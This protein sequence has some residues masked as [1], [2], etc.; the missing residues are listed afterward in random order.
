MPHD[1]HD[2]FH[3]EGMSSSGHPYRPDNE[4][5][6]TYWQQ[7]EIAVRELLVE[8]GITTPAE[9]NAQIEAMDAR[10]PAQGAAVV[11]RAW[12][13]PAFKTRLLAE[14]LHA[15]CQAG[16]RIALTG[17]T[18]RAVDN[19]LLTL[20]GLAPELPL[21]K[22]GARNNDELAA[23]GVDGVLDKP[24]RAE[25]LLGRV[26][27]ALRAGPASAGGAPAPGRVR[28]TFSSS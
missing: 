23:A 15:L 24:L 14:V 18:H 9:I 27:A 20:R 11:A 7:I 21:V 3:H 13:D 17:F 10:S 4:Q 25:E 28:R 12:A 26:E 6:L 22:L 5:P 19:A 2:H 8:K 16:C 1:H